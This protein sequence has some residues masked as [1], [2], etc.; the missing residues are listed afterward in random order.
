MTIRFKWSYHKFA[1]SRTQEA[2]RV[3]APELR[4]GF[5]QALWSGFSNEIADLRIAAAQVL[6]LDLFVVFRFDCATI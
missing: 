4:E 5:I 2:L 6:L 1:F 3:V